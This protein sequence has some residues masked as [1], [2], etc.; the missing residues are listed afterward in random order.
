VLVWDGFGLVWQLV[1]IGFESWSCADPVLVGLCG[2]PS[3]VSTLDRAVV[4][5]PS[6]L[7]PDNELIFGLGN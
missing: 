2:N 4:C 1:M 5:Q 6:I 3:C 7:S